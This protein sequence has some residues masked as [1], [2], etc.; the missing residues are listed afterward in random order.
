MCVS[1][2]NKRYNTYYS[3]K[4]A[5]IHHNFNLLVIFHFFCFP[6]DYI[7]IYETELI[8]PDNM[9]RILLVG[10]IYRKE[11]NTFQQGCAAPDA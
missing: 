10:N 6:Y 8:I 2:L 1:L 3:K 4:C 5:A 9:G 7:I 11:T